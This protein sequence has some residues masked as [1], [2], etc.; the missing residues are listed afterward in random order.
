[1]LGS[2]VVGCHL[3]FVSCFVFVCRLPSGMMLYGN[4]SFDN[5][6]LD[7]VRVGVK[8]SV[9]FSIRIFFTGLSRFS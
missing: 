1:M 3:F 5:K 6:E 7:R 8:N 9:V 4:L 2:G